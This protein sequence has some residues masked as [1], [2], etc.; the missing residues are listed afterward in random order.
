MI[1]PEPNHTLLSAMLAALRDL[2]SPSVEITDEVQQYLSALSDFSPRLSGFIAKRPEL[3]AILA[4]EG[5]FSRKRLRKHLRIRQNRWRERVRDE[6]QAI[7]RF[8]RSELIRIAIRDLCEIADIQMITEELANLAE[9]T[10]SAVYD[11]Q[12]E[13]QRG[14]YGQPICGESGEPTAMCVIGMG[15]QGGRELNFSSDVDV[16]FVYGSDGETTGGEKSP[17]GNQEFF[18]ILAQSFSDVLTRVT[19]DGFLYRI[20][21]RLRPEGDSGRLAV[22]LIAVEIYYHTYGQN[23]ERQALLKARPIA[24]DEGVGERFMSIITPFTYRRYV[25]ELEI[26]EVLRD[27]ERLR[28][29]MLESIGSPEKQAVNFK[30]GYGGIRD[31]EFF[32]QA[33]Q[34]LYGK[35]YPEIKL[36]GTLVSLQRMYESHLLHSKDYET[37]TRSYKFLRR[38]EHRLQMVN[39]QQ[40]YE[41]PEGE[42]DRDRLARSMSEANYEALKARYDL[43]TADV[44]RIYEGVFRRDEF[45]DASGRLIDATE[46]NDDVES[47]LRSYE[48]D[49]P[50]Q[51]FAFLSALHKASEPHLQP[52]HSRLFQAIL[53][54]LLTVLKESPDPDMALSNFEKLVS[55]F[56]ARTALFE[57]LGEQRMMFNLLVSVISCSSFLTRLVL[58]DPSLMETLSSEELLET[59]IDYRQLARHL[60]LIASAHP[61]ESLREHLLRVQN[62]AM[63][64]SGVRFILAVSGVEQTGRDLAEIADF[65]LNQSI[66]PVHQRMADRYPLFTRDHADEIAILGYGKLGGRDFNVASDCDVV[67]VYEGASSNEEVSASEYFQRWAPKYLDYLESKSPLGFL[68]EPDARL[69]PNGKNSPMACSWDFFENYYRMEAQLWEKMALSRSRWIGGAASIESKLAELKDEVLFSRSLT[70][71]EIGSIVDMR[72]KIEREK[73]SE[74]IKAGAGGLVDVE[75]IAQT[76]VLHYG[77]EYPAM[78][79]TATITSLRAASENELLP[80]AEAEQLIDSYLF[81]REI[82]NRLRIVNNVSLDTLPT[83]TDELEALTRRYALRIHSEKPSPK[84]FLQWISVR[85]QSV[86]SIFRTFFDRLIQNGR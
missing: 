17:I 57:T 24:G 79:L 34:M 25:D 78:R 44:R 6:E 86:R 60:E 28:N 76:L 58:R 69:R 39:E 82:E 56:R 81:L 62:A 21:T 68:Y 46:Y 66:Q 33:V 4:E 40:V 11:W 72:E 29:K 47:I 51:A 38:L 49:D 85:T 27:I 8:H 14:V 73:Q 23:W 54:R 12:W 74:T 9:V 20:D 2:E 26:A 80:K 16:M 42:D 15:K 59:P 67:F 70:P 36:A 71:D 55:S 30:N 64:R 84:K 18:T 3:F 52:K 61:N 32:V 77:A 63:L 75:F 31:I 45:E 13:R 35:Q 48:F 5:D 65:V 1:V 22:P 53:P 83:D 7:R 37:L 10:H 43:I 41:L 19:E 50:R